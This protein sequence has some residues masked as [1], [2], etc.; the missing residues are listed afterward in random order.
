MSA[1]G[2]WLV[3][4][5]PVHRPAVSVLTISKGAERM[6]WLAECAASVVRATHWDKD[7][8]HLVSVSGEWHG[9]KVNDLA[10]IAR[11]RYLVVLMD[12]DRLRPHFLTR[13][14]DEAR[15]GA[16]FVYTN[17]AIFGDREIPEIHLPAFGLNTFRQYVCPWTT[18]LI[19]AELWQELKGYDPDQD[20]QDTDFWVRAAKLG[21]TCLHIHEPL[22]EAREHA[23]Q[24]GRMMDHSSALLRLQSKHPDVYPSNF[25]NPDYG[26]RHVEAGAGDLAQSANPFDHVP[27][28]HVPAR[29][30]DPADPGERRATNRMVHGGPE[31]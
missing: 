10:T 4:R 23:A 5:T 31:R 18:A 17:H 9:N 8:E 28:V 29:Y 3:P 13:C 15:A 24:G 27:R 26:K 7:V 12:D 25:L 16:D 1:P 30:E 14:L 6:G 2:V 19:R 21:A 20:Y 22:W 11:G